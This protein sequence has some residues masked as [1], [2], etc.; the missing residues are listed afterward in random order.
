[1]AKDTKKLVVQAV[2]NIL[3][4]KVP[5]NLEE[6]I[7]RTGIT[8]QT[9]QNNFEHKG[10]DGIF[11]FIYRTMIEEAQQQLFRYNADELPIEIFADIILNVS[12]KYRKEWH[13][14]VAA[15]RN[16]QAIELSTEL[17]LP[18][19]EKRY[20]RLIKLHHLFPVVTPRSLL[21]YWNG[22]LYSAL[23]IWLSASYPVEPSVFKP[24]FIFLMKNSLQTVIYSELG[25]RE[26]KKS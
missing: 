25:F 23:E 20:E 6:I 10:L 11:D 12:W 18:W 1:M 17:S 13:T 3:D 19:V 5:L 15:N 7:R 26:E 21:K 9:I 4:E 24:V 14:L 16:H 22:C 2:F 8:R